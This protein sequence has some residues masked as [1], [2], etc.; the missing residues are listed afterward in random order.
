MMRAH[1]IF[2]TAFNRVVYLA[3][4]DDG[5]MSITNDAEAVV[6]YYAKQFPLCRIV[7]K[8]TMGIWD[9]LKH[10][11]GVFTGFATWEGETP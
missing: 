6:K 2:V 1:P 10:K 5:A 7:Y 8:D 9:E 3:D 4:A 11:D